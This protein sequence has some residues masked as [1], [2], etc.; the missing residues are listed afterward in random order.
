MFYSLLIRKREKENR[1]F[2]WHEGNARPD[3]QDPMTFFFR[4]TNL[5]EK[6]KKKRGMNGVGWMIEIKYFQMDSI[7]AWMNIIIWEWLVGQIKSIFKIKSVSVDSEWFQ[8][9]FLP[10]GFYFYL[11]EIILFTPSH[12]FPPS[13]ICHVWAQE[14]TKASDWMR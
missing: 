10:R 12:A 1:A 11:N 3:R 6:K 8:H 7:I 14:R 5:F 9:D 2:C 4:T 13:M